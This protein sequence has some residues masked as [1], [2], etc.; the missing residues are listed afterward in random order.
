M[1]RKKIKYTVVV[2]IMATR[3]KFVTLDAVSGKLLSAVVRDIS[4]I[5]TF[6][7]K[8]SYIVGTLKDEIK[9]D[10]IK[11]SITFLSLES[12][13]A[14]IKRVDIPHLPLNEVSD[15]LKW[16][17]R[18]MFSFDMERAI[19]DFDI[20]GE[21]AEEDGSKKHDVIMAIVIK[22]T[23]DDNISI[24]KEA[25]FEKI[26]G[27]NVDSFGLAN[28][29]GLT[30]EGKEEKTCAVL[31][32]NYKNS[33]VNIYRSRRLVF[34]RNIPIGLDHI[35]RL[36]IGPVT[37]DTGSVE[38]EPDDIK[39]L[40][41]LGIPADT[42]NLLNNR[43][44]GKH[45]LALIRPALESLS[46]EIKR[47]FDYYSL[48][49]GGRK[50][51]KIYLMGEGCAYRNLDS[52]IS[53][54]TMTKTECL[55]VPSEVIDRSGK[56]ATEEVIARVLPLVGVGRGG[57]NIKV[58]LLPLEYKKESM[59]KVQKI[60]IRMVGFTTFLILMMAFIL[61]NIRMTDY[62]TRLISADSQR[63][64]LSEVKLIYNK[65]IE[66]EALIKA[67][68]SDSV[69][70]ISMLKELSNIIPDNIVLTNLDIDHQKGVIKFN[71]TVYAGEDVG[72]V[73]LADFMKK[74]ESSPFFKG[75][76]L[77]SSQKK[78]VGDRRTVVFDITCNIQR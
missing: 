52:F 46:N 59:Q 42:E 5:Q 74:M 20:V 6:E 50:V 12:D 25:G 75:I 36:V 44:Q 70:T 30:P 26:G 58:D 61:V 17:T 27:V 39:E 63:K 73:I 31:N 1:I 15:A 37:T 78:L 13:S 43:L 16:R 72:E 4:S 76:N 21:H 23:I 47:S 10:V 19:L 55:K 2:E 67:V 60:S 51:E 24:L 57:Q 7:E 53:K 41:A 28:I 40:K 33:T 11:N 9:P 35:K 77:G 68:K 45:L 3:L 18:S 71:G 66:R 29:I 48:H 34:V 69:P 14:N 22:N 49:L 8:K 56:G 64:V 38:L 65:V 54:V 62:R 32:V